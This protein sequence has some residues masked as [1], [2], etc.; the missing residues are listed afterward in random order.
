[1]LVPKWID[2]SAKKN[3]IMS[4]HVDEMYKK[5]FKVCK[6]TNL[7]TNAATSAQKKDLQRVFK[8]K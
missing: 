6:K 1:M 3:D 8:G 7:T 2:W 4:I 5:I